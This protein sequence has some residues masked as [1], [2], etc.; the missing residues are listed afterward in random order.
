LEKDNSVFQVVVIKDATSQLVGLMI[1]SIED[2]VSTTETIDTNVVDREAVKGTIYINDRLVT[3]LDEGLLSHKQ[4]AK[5]ISVNLE[6][7]A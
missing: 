3:V 7:V 4:V 5:N 2:I 1:D 6:K